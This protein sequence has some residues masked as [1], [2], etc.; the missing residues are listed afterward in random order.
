MSYGEQ[1]LPISK[2]CGPALERPDDA[3]A[4][5]A[6]VPPSIRIAG[7]GLGEQIAAA[8]H[9]GDFPAVLRFS[10]DRAFILL[11][12]SSGLVAHDLCR[13]QYEDM[14]W[15]PAR[16]RIVSPRPIELSAQPGRFCA[17]AALRSW[18]SLAGIAAGPVFRRV[19][20][21]GRLGSEALSAGDLAN[22]FWH[23]VLESR[24]GPG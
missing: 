24:S 5:E 9:R 22:A 1:D 15:E 7:D 11:S 20:A 13:L 18:I 17:V 12:Y 10:R 4:D 16:L 3:S 2:V 8:A 19:K 14:I 21:N 23:A 6:N